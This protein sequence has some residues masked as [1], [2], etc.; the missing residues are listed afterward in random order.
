MEWIQI[1]TKTNNNEEWKKRNWVSKL[2][3]ID[4]FT[5]SNQ[6]KWALFGF[7]EHKLNCIWS[8]KRHSSRSSS[9]TTN[10]N[11]FA[12]RF[13]NHVFWSKRNRIRNKIDALTVSAMIFSI[14]ALDSVILTTAL[15][16]KINWN[17]ESFE[18]ER[19]LTIIS[20]ASFQN[21]FTIPLTICTYS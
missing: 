4:L 13:Y 5:I 21:G 14:I 9:T 18:I 17:M 6:L 19:F 8:G 20:S 15:T 1:D 11:R 10:N 16:Y 12:I 7:S 3:W 2:K